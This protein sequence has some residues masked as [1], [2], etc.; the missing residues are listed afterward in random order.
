MSKIEV[1]IFSFLFPFLTSIL[2]DNQRSKRDR[3]ETNIDVGSS[4]CMCAR[5][6]VA[7]ESDKMEE[8]GK[9]ALGEIWGTGQTDQDPPGQTD[10]QVGNINNINKK[11]KEKEG[12]K[13]TI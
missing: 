4:E 10:L 2:P 7:F 11:G 12:Y 9:R 3:A 13:I 1:I 5:V 8:T 6:L